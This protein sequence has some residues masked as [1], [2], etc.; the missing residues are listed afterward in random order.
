VVLG[1]LGYYLASVLDFYGLVYISAG[2]ERLILFVYPTL[3]VVM[4]ALAFGTKITRRVLLALLLTY[5]G[6]A[7][8]VRTETANSTGPDVALGVALIF[9]CALTYA[10]YLVGSGQ[11]I[12]RVGSLRFTAL[13]MIVSTLAMLVHFAVVGGSYFGHAR[14]V[15]LD[16]VLL[17][18]ICT[19]FPVFLLAEGI[20]RRA[21][22]ASIMA[23]VG[24]VS[25]IALAYLFLDEPVHLVQGFGTFLV[26]VGATVVARA[27]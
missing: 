16:G 19:V 27:R 11:L 6:V 13:A 15:Y 9:G 18:L 7:L 1:V 26:L 25:T 3:V 23:A 22:P 5:A 2:L 12:P 24:P 20:R 10:V 17:A 21:G 14:E 8:A 4:S